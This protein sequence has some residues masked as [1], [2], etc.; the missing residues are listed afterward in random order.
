MFDHSGDAA[1]GTN[2]MVLPDNIGEARG[3]QPSGE[4]ARWT[5]GFQEIGGGFHR[6]FLGYAVLKRKSAEVRDWRRTA[7]KLG[8]IRLRNVGIA[9]NG[10]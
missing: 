7:R 5:E 3:A 4:R 6:L 8:M 1:G 9:V 2:E 10:N